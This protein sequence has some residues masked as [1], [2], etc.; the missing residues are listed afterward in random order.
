MTA[1]WSK[2]DFEYAVEYLRAKKPDEVRKIEQEY[3]NLTSYSTFFL[4][5][6][7]LGVKPSDAAK[8]LNVSQGAV[9][10]MRFRLKT[11]LRKEPEK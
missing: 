9:R 4:C 5:L 11:K 1:G 3:Y 6:G 7:L 10:A 8:V 2:A